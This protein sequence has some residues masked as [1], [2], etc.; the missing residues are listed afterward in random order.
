M[1]MTR[2]TEMKSS[3]KLIE[4]ENIG[5]VNVDDDRK[6]REPRL[7]SVGMQMI[8]AYGKMTLKK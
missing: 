4:N 1:T 2:S 6:G 8:T 7:K 5:I 3:C